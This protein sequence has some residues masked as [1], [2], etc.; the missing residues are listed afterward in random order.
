MHPAITVFQAQGCVISSKQ[1][2]I[3]I[4]V[5]R[6][7]ERSSNVRVTQGACRREKNCTQLPYVSGHSWSINV[8]FQ[9]QTTNYLWRK[10]LL[11]LHNF[12]TKEE[13]VDEWILNIHTRSICLALL[14]DW[15]EV[16]G[17]HHP[18]FLSSYLSHL[19]QLHVKFE[20]QMKM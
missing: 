4:L 12:L 16:R 18:T 1:K 19:R 5:F 7:R 20:T 15:H 8:S 17:R 9:N 14:R 11:L 13:T 2:Y 10:K 3:I 6:E